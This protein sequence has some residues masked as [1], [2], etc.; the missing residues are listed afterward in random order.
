MKNFII[1]LAF[2]A[3]FAG[4]TSFEA[5]AQV[6]STTENSVQASATPSVRRAGKVL[7]VDGRK[8]N[9]AETYDYISE[10]C[11]QQ[12]AQRWINSARIYGAGKGLLISSAV[13]I[14]VGMASCVVGTAMIAGVAVGMGLGAAMTGGMA[15]Q[16]LSPEAQ[17]TVKAGAALA[18]CGATLA[19]VGFST[20]VA[21]AVCVPVGKSRM[22]AIA[23][24]CN[25]ANSGRDITMN[26]GS[27]PH[28]IGVTLNF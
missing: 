11:G 28:G 12:Y 14:P 9:A 18:I 19:A 3:I 20:L 6:I 24:S 10:H 21:G 5:S 25:S 15:D 26:F 17:R 8:L 27:C 16:D 13:T 1:T 23:S 7:S 22:N 4:I 2:A